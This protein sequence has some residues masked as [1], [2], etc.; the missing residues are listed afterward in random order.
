MDEISGMSLSSVLKSFFLNQIANLFDDDAKKDDI[1]ELKSWMQENFNVAS[2]SG[3]DGE[4]P[5]P[6]APADVEESA[7]DTEKGDYKDSTPAENFYVLQEF[8][9]GQLD[10]LNENLKNIPG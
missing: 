3:S 1:E 9:Q 6:E 5:E 7:E 4:S 8:I 2:D 10:I